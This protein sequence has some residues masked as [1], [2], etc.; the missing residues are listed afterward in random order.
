[1]VVLAACVL[2]AAASPTRAQDIVGSPATEGHQPAC[3][4]EEALSRLQE[5]NARFVSGHARFR[6]VQKEDLVTGRVRFLE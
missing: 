6:M 3:A 5:G 4:A 1:M 2:A